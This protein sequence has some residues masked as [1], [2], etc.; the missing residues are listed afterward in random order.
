ME[1]TISAAESEYSNATTLLK[2]D[3]SNFGVAGKRKWSKLSIS[4]KQ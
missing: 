3:C 4:W 1:K 2:F